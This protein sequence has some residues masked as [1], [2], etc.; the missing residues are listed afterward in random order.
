MASKSELGVLRA[1]NSDLT[2]GIDLGGTK[3]LGVLVSPKG[4]LLDHIRTPTPKGQDAIVEC[5]E[6]LVSSLVQL[7]AS[8]YKSNVSALGV[9][10][11]GLVTRQGSLNF[12]ANLEAGQN[13]E[14]KKI[15]E[16]K[17]PSMAIAVENDANCAGWAEWKFGAGQGV[18]DL[19]VITLGTGVGGSAIVNKNLVIGSQGFALEPGH[20]VIDPNGPLC[21][22]GRKGCWEKFA[23]GTALKELAKKYALEG[24]ASLVLELANNDPSAITGEHVATALKQSDVQAGN[25]MNEFSLGV[26]IGLANLANIFDPEK[27]IISGGLVQMGDLLLDPV[28]DWF[29]NQPL[30]YNFRNSINIEP[31]V[32]GEM[33]GA[34][35]A[36]DLALTNDDSI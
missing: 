1:P 35:G 7:G 19:V 22:C 36:A 4:E 34:W 9:G 17:F 15:L 21:N 10:V 23:S 31:A 26:A 20:M 32:L 2:I 28:R 27:F 11:P 25:I 24:K 3:V 14:L 33:A 12:A 6:D 13:F 29:S 16:K 30:G 18:D 5:I 8:N